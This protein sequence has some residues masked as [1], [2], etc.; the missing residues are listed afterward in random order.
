MAN[1]PRFDIDLQKRDLLDLTGADGVAA[2]FARLRYDTAT[3]TVQTAGALGLTEAV[4]R[5]IRRIEML[6]SR[7][8]FARTRHGVTRRRRSFARFA[9]F[10]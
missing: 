4:A 3:R 10:F 9:T 8:A 6:A 5:P 2:W 1:D 7:A